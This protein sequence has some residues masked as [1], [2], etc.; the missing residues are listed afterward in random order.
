MPI[1]GLGERIKGLRKE[2]KMTQSSLAELVETSQGYIAD[3]EKG[4]VNPS[5]NTLEKIANVLQIQVKC[6]FDSEAEKEIEIKYTNLIPITVNLVPLPVLG[7]IPAGIPIEA[8]ENIIDYVYVPE[9]EIKNGS[10]FYL[11]VQGDSMINSGIKNGYRV[12]VKRQPD[13]ENGEIAVVRVNSHDATLKR[14]RKVDGQV[15]LYPDNPEYDP[16]FIKE[17]GAEFIGKVVK[18]EFDPN[19]K[20]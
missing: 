11:Q 10:Y 4:R 7:K 12:L 2:K 19:K 20:Y 16:I 6:L 5:I 1:K 3:I 14:V 8:S 13:V 17:E 15:I 18:V 9:N